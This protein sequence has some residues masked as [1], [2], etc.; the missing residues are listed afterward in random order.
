MEE[1]RKP[2]VSYKIKVDIIVI[3]LSYPDNLI[4]IQKSRRK[5][6]VYKLIGHWYSWS[7]WNLKLRF[8]VRGG[9]EETLCHTKSRVDIMVFALS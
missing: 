1:G 5:Y 2:G 3:S 7:G 6:P 8:W 4:L 9:R